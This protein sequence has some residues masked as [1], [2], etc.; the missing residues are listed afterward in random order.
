MESSI[1]NKKAITRTLLEFRA[2]DTDN[3]IN[4]ALLREM[5]EKYVTVTRTLRE[6][7]NRYR[8]VFAALGEG[9]VVQRKDG[10]IVAANK[11]AEKVLGLSEDELYG[12]TSIDPRWRA[13]HEDGTHFPG[14]EHPAML[15]LTDGKPRYEVIMGV[16]KPN[17]ELAWISINTQPMFQEEEQQPSAVVATFTD[18]TLRIQWEKE[19][20]RV[21][22]TDHLTQIFN[23]VKGTESLCVEIERAQRYEDPLSIVMFDIDH[24][25]K[26]NDVHGHDVGDSVLVEVSKTIAK[27]LRSTDVFVRWGG[28]EFVIILPHTLIEDSLS[29]AE[30]FRLEIESIKKEEL[31]AI[32]ASFG[33]TAFIIN[34]S[35][36][37]II[38]RADEAL[39][40]AK[41]DGRNRVAVQSGSVN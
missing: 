32:T 2:K 28:E 40:K 19:L 20:R 10:I 24:F 29:L 18:I 6:S 4:N 23:R 31:P 26:V 8:S 41:H 13:V 35:S 38:K 1:D 17:G 27:H 3:R 11:S 7:E 21:S 15:T 9:L 37:T 30:R 36:E 14:E 34:D 22:V 25:K 5:I 12:R 33:V 39:Y 16:H